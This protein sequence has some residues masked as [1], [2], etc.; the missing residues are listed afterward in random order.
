MN[1]A[2]KLIIVSVLTI[3]L[4]LETLAAVTMPLCGESAGTKHSAT[5]NSD[6]N[7]EA[8]AMDSC[9]H[10]N[11]KLGICQVGQDSTCDQSGHCVL[12]A[13][14]ALLSQTVP[15]LFSIATDV[16]SPQIEVVKLQSLA[17]SLFKPPISPLA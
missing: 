9:E 4:P 1:R 7:A 8:M 6:A 17:T 10:T 2:I 11:I 15:A 12:C 16:L 13:A 14:Q 3:C 5:M